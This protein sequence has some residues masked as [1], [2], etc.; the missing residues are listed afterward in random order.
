LP[1]SMRSSKS[2]SPVSDA[3][4][5][6]DECA[7][8]QHAAPLRARAGSTGDPRPVRESKDR[9][10]VHPQDNDLFPPMFFNKTASATREGRHCGAKV[11][12]RLSR[13]TRLRKLGER[14]ILPH[15]AP[16]V[17][18]QKNIDTASISTKRPVRRAG[19]LRFSRHWNRAPRLEC[20]ARRAWFSPS[21]RSRRSCSRVI[22]SFTAQ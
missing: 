20:R 4:H 1:E 15:C 11:A 17:T 6:T 19:S 9:A 12:P 21:S 14:L 13:L 18:A 8:H 7:G 16:F 3:S 2:E 10:A 5:T 22:E